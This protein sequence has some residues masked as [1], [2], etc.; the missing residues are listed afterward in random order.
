VRQLLD[1][2]KADHP[3]A[4]TLRSAALR[5][6]EVAER[7]ADAKAKMAKGGNLTPNGLNSA[8]RDALPGYAAQLQA[9]RAPI[10]KLARE[11]RERRAAIRVKQPDPA[12]LAAAIERMEI[13]TFLR[14]MEPGKRS[15]LL[16]GTQDVRL[17]EAALTA[18]PELIGVVSEPLV[19][20]TESRYLEMIHGPEAK[21]VAELEDVVAE[22][23][24]A[25]LVARS[26]LQMETGLD[27][28]T[29]DATVG[30]A[31]K[32]AQPA[33]LIKSSD[34]KTVTCEIGADGK[35]NYHAAT[36]YELES[37]EYYANEEAF[38]ASRGE[39][40]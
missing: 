5:T 14:E 2:I 26:R 18:P 11:A 29:F 34:G 32:A 7:F 3:K 38:N 28:R 13:R 33:W 15:A 25:A 19:K 22:A 12:N 21:A 40:A 1:R 6:I 10:D 17:L 16:A 37:G 27:S 8:L 39:T 31:E 9:A 20:Q 36:P 24:A 30:P 4:D 35:G 23:N